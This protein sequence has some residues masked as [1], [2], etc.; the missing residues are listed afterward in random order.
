MEAD[1]RG[2]RAHP[3]AMQPSSGLQSTDDHAAARWLAQGVRLGVWPEGS[4]S[5]KAARAVRD[6]WR[7]RAHVVRQHTANGLRVHNSL[8][9]HT[10]G[11]VR[12]K[13]RH[14]CTQQDLEGLLPEANPGLAVPSSL[15]LLDG[16]RPQIET[17]AKAVTQSLQ[18]TPAYEPLLTVDGSGTMVA[19]TIGVETGA[20]GRF[21]TVGHDAASCRCVQRTNISTGKRKGQGHVKHGHPYLEWAS[22]EAAPCAIRFHP[23]GQRF[24]QRQH[25]T[26]HLMVARKAGAHT[27]ARAWSYLRR[28]LVP[29]DGHNAL[30]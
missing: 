18:H 21:P 28:D 29:L 30:G 17:L 20:M 24:Y 27:L 19:Q 11:R 10:G 25:A 3:A 5:P 12:V 1:D 15:A 9:R 26:S 6:V 16:L 7:K 2:H 13:H 23:T 8:A 14:E 4:L 22:I